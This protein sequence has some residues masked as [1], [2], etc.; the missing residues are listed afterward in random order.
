[1][2]IELYSINQKKNTGMIVAGDI[3]VFLFIF[4]LFCTVQAA[5]LGINILLK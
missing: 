1:M 2:D 5:C 4:E 3:Y